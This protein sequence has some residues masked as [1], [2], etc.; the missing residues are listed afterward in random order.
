MDMSRV[1]PI[2]CQFGVGGVLCAIGIW[3]G[4]RSGYL[5]LRHAEDRRLLLVLVG[6]FVILLAVSC[7]FTFWSP[8][9]A[10]GSAR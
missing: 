4:I 3:C 9:W 1:W 2:V 5:N 6:G 8:H 10:K 7:V